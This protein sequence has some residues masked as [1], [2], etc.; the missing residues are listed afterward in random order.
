VTVDPSFDLDVP[1]ALSHDGPLSLVVI[2]DSTAFTDHQ[3][4]RLPG[5]PHLYPQ[6]AATALA[7]AFDREVTPT[8]L[9]RPGVTVRDA[10]RTVTKDQHAQFD[11]LAHA[12][13][14]II[15]VGSFDH[16]PAGVPPALEAA[17]AFLRP[18]AVRRR[19]RRAL[20]TAYPW[21]V[22]ATAG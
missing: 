4:P 12:D 11:V 21:L 10:V 14:V 6:V 7:A 1:R 2:G 3:G 18:T 16:A 20:A 13:A 17:A 8:V 19:A 15:G 22:S 5:T 9:A